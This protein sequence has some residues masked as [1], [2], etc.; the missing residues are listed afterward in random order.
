MFIRVSFQTIQVCIK[1]VVIGTASHKKLFATTRSNVFSKNNVENYDLKAPSRLYNLIFLMLFV[2]CFCVIRMSH[3][4]CMPFLWQS[5]ILIC[6]P[7][8]I[9]MYSYATCIYSNVIQ[10]SLVCTRVSTVYHL[11]ALTCYSYD[12]QMYLHVSRMP[13]VCTCMYLVVC[14]LYVVICISLVFSL[15]HPYVGVTNTPVG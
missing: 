5:Y 8:V 11:F 1:S 2:F 7:Q 3:V 12:I 9:R 15:C 10:I 6:H 4:I 13:L 14:H